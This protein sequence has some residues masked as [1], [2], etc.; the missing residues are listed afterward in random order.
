MAGMVITSY[1]EAS[2]PIHVSFF[3]RLIFKPAMAILSLQFALE[4]L[5]VVF[6]PQNS[7]RRASFFSAGQD[8]LP[9][10]NMQY[11]FD[12]C[13]KEP[14]AKNDELKGSNPALH[15]SFFHHVQVLSQ[16]CKC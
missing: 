9:A 12:L 4:L 3:G 10:T 15:F 2:L 8:A 13:V 5:Y 6:T 14:R 11:R 16:R 7:D 1:V